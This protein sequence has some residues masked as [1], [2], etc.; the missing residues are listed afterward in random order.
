MI[1]HFTSSWPPFYI[2]TTLP[3]HRSKNRVTV[4]L[5]IS[6]DFDE[7]SGKN[8]SM[9]MISISGTAVSVNY[10]SNI[11]V[12]HLK[13]TELISNDVLIHELNKNKIIDKVQKDILLNEEEWYFIQQTPIV[14]I[15]E[16]LLMSFFKNYSDDKMPLDRDK[17][18]KIFRNTANYFRVLD[19]EISVHILYKNLIKRPNEVFKLLQRNDLFSPEKILLL[20]EKG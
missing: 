10:S 19:K 15:S 18:K 1:A 12:N 14:E 3:D 11:T 20:I 5:G 2:A 7:I 17:A 6:V 9:F 13:I 8:K 4:I 16:N